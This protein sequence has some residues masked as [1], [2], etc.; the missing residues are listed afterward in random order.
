L[1]STNFR[2]KRTAG[3]G[4]VTLTITLNHPSNGTLSGTT[5]EVILHELLHAATLGAIEVGRY[6]SA[7]GTKV[8]TAVRELL[9]GHLLKAVKQEPE[10]L[11]FAGPDGIVPHIGKTLPWRHVAI[12][13]VDHLR[14]SGSKVIMEHFQHSRGHTELM[15]ATEMTLLPHSVHWQG[16]SSVSIP[17]R[18]WSMVGTSEG[19]RTREALAHILA[20]LTKRSASFLSA[21]SGHTANIRPIMSSLCL[22][23]RSM[24]SICVA[25][26]RCQYTTSLRFSAVILLLG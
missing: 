21:Q 4:P 18:V 13:W 16:V 3:S 14:P 17:C 7:E 20:A 22:A 25:V 11:L 26:G 15:G 6:K 9:E 2:G 12:G 1:G 10:A 24:S 23:I 8:G 19:T 5:P